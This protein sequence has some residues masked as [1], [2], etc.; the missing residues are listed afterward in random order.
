MPHQSLTDAKYKISTA[1]RKL[2]PMNKPSSPPVLAARLILISKS[3][4]N[5]MY[6]KHVREYG[7]TVYSVFK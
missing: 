4:K 3:N 1:L 6:L 7:P 2:K 5:P